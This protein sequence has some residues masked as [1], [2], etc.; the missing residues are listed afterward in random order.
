MRTDFAWLGAVF[1]FLFC[2]AL[3]FAPNVLCPEI[4]DMSFS[5]AVKQEVHVIHTHH[6]HNYNRVT[7]AHELAEEMPD[8]SVKRITIARRWEN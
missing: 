8:G 3:I 4:Y 1:I 5:P 2:T 7:E 6:H